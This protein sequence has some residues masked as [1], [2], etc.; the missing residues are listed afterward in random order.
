VH[1][2]SSTEA[3]IC[4][5]GILATALSLDKKKGPQV[6]VEEEEEENLA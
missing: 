4:Y 3:A 1:L 5:V 6:E 2:C